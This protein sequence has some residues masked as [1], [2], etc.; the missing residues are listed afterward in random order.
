MENQRLYFQWLGKKLGFKGESDWYKLRASDLVRWG[1][2]G[3]LTHHY[4]GSPYRALSTVFPDIDWKP[5]KFFIVPK[6]F[7]QDEE[8]VAKF[9]KW[10]EPKLGISNPSQW[11]DH[12][13]AHLI[14]YG[15]ITLLRR[16]RGLNKLVSNFYPGMELDRDGWQTNMKSRAQQFLTEIIRSLMQEGTEVESNCAPMNMKYENTSKPMFFDV[17][18]PRFN[19]CLEHQGQQHYVAHTFWGDYKSLVTRDTEKLYA[20][21]RSHI[22]LLH[23]PYWWDHQRS[24]IIS[25][26]KSVSNHFHRLRS[27]IIHNILSSA[28]C[29][30]HRTT[31]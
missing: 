21:I 24:T 7:W 26:L 18:I 23:V 28:R 11:N 8:N 16:T 31:R 1:G 29:I 4:G 27:M 20:C 5:W 6:R 2:G 14:A 30:C 9:F 12:T 3:L 25:A 19:L 13:S 22:S 15:G 17:W 10:V